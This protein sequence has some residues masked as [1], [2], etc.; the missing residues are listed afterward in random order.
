MKIKMITTVTSE[1]VA[2]LVEHSINE[3]KPDVKTKR[4]AG[5]AIELK[6]GRRKFVVSV[7]KPVRKNHKR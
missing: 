7:G 2:D 1:D 3:A 6:I 4:G 5:S